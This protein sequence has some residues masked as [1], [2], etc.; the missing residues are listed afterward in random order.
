[1]VITVLATDRV[2]WVL[3]ACNADLEPYIR[4]V[5]DLACLRVWFEIRDF[6]GKVIGIVDGWSGGQIFIE[7]R[8]KNGGLVCFLKSRK[9][10][11]EDRKE[12][13]GCTLVVFRLHVEV[14]I[15]PYR[16]RAC[17]FLLVGACLFSCLV[18]LRC[19]LGGVRVG[20][21]LC[22]SWALSRCFWKLSLS[23]V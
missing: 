18:C 10:I 17:Y 22:F 8:E 19:I 2:F 6:F 13:G 23:D 4:L 21:F 5:F 16:V 14:K 15:D 12:S 20:F 3:V 9:V 1:M 7:P 11:F